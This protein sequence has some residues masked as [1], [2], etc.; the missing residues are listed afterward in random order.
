MI[1]TMRFTFICIEPVSYLL[2]FRVFKQR[3]QMKLR[4]AGKPTTLTEERFAK[5]DS[6]GF[7][8]HAKSNKDWQQ[9]EFLRK[10]PVVEAVWQKHFLSLCAFKKEYG[11]FLPI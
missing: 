1:A 10:Q 2:V 5:L 7:V 6:V 8:W 3:A 11:E 9:L 4:E